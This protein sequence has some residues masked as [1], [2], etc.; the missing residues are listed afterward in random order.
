M[1]EPLSINQMEIFILQ[2]KNMKS[3]EIHLSSDSTNIYWVLVLRQ[4]LIKELEY[5][6]RENN[7]IA[8]MELIF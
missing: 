1:R 8:T 3:K 6:G 7:Q 4:E 5:H 2:F